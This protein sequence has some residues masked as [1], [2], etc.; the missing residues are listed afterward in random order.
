MKYGDQHTNASMRLIY[1]SLTR[2]TLREY[3]KIGG[4]SGEYAPRRL[5]QLVAGAAAT[6]SKGSCPLYG[7]DL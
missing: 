1:T 4:V 3:R 5:V 2:N 7:Q 6:W